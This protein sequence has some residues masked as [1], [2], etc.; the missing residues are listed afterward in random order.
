MAARALIREIAR[1]TLTPSV[2]EIDDEEQATVST[3]Y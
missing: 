1:P 3:T 2:I